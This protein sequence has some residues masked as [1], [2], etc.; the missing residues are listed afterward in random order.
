MHFNEFEQALQRRQCSHSCRPCVLS[1]NY[2]TYS[3]EPVASISP[4]Q[5]V[6]SAHCLSGN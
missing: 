2:R 5:L 3:A 6:I 1:T 4:Q